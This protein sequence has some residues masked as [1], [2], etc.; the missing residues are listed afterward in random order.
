MHANIYKN[1]EYGIDSQI[2][3]N[4]NM[5]NKPFKFI[6][7]RCCGDEDFWSWH[8]SMNVDD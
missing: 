5:H 4:R 8:I 6:L 2:K 3:N 1:L 7:M